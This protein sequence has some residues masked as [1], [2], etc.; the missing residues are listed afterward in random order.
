[1]TFYLVIDGEF[2]ISTIF[3]KRYISTLFCE[4]AYSAPYFL[5]F[6][7]WFRKIYVFCTYFTCFSFPPYFDHLCITQC[8]YWTPL[9]PYT[10][11]CNSS[12]CWT[13]S[14]NLL[15]SSVFKV[16]AVKPRWSRSHVLTDCYVSGLDFLSANS[17]VSRKASE[18]DMPSSTVMSHFPKQL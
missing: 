8:T 15:H 6:P 3:T 4:N 1:M 17:V 14:L 5:K 10:R 9:G 2:R 11:R 12:R 13:P 18:P 16:V 7:L